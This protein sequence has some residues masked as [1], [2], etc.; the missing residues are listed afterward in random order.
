M[1][2]L[3]DVVMQG[4]ACDDCLRIVLSREMVMFLAAHL[5]VI[6]AGAFGLRAMGGL[7]G[8]LAQRRWKR[9]PIQAIEASILLALASAGMAVILTLATF[10]PPPAPSSTA[11]PPDQLPPAA[12]RAQG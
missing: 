1:A 4:L 7:L 2:A 10:A 5:L 3:S 6:G 8:A 9:A 12:E 11:Q